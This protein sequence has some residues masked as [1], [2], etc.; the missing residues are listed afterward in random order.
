MIYL[1]V[2]EKGGVGKSTL[3]TAL[4]V[5]L[6]DSGRRVAVLDTDKQLH[7]ARAV[8]QAEPNITVVSE[9]DARKIPAV[10]KELANEF[11]DVVAD[12][13][14]KLEDEAR[15]LMVMADIAVFPTEPTI[16]CLRSTKTSINVLEYARKL[17][18]GK[19]HSAWLVLNKAKKRTR[20][21]QEVEQL[22]PKLGL[23]VAKTAVRD[24]QAFPEADQQGTVVTRMIASTSS[25][26]KATQDIQNLFAELIEREYPQVVH[27]G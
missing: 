7:T 4:A 6:H 2:N 13:P 22:A 3:A 24:L 17:T 23:S 8:T 18:G 11:E 26:E 16:K 14:A 12:A 5:Y 15:A 27:Y 20:I 10:V 21:Y 1:F 9:F 19:P 25:I